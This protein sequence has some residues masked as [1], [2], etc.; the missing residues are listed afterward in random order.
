MCHGV[1]E[2]RILEEIHRIFGGTKRANR[3]I[4]RFK[5]NRSITFIM[6][7]TG[8]VRVSWG[9]LFESWL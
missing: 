3:Q 2:T 8:N 6:V 9:G 7:N 5:W 1:Q 4:Q